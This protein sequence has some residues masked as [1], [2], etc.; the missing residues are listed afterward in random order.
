MNC[1]KISSSG[2]R[3]QDR[4]QLFQRLV[5]TVHDA[6]LVHSKNILFA[7]R[8]SWLCWALPPRTSSASR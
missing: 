4:E 7:N 6:V 8:V 1:W 2:A 5:E 3:L